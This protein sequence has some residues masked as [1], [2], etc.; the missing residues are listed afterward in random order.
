MAK[1]EVLWAKRQKKLAARQA[2][3]KHL[4]MMQ[5][6]RQQRLAARRG[7]RNPQTQKVCRL[8][9]CVAAESS[10]RGCAFCVQ[11]SCMSE[12]AC[13]PW[14]RVLGFVCAE[15]RSGLEGFADRGMR[16]DVSFLPYV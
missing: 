6:K 4:Q 8:L 10:V 1:A 3:I 14:Q 5:L 13:R 16:P 12:H 7:Q 11:S 15:R 9:C 2:R